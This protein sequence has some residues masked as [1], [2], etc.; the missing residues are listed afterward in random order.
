MMPIQHEYIRSLMI[1]VIHLEAFAG[2]QSTRLLQEWYY[3][4]IDT[5]TFRSRSE[6]DVDIIVDLFTAR[7]YLEYALSN[8]YV[9]LNDAMDLITRSEISLNRYAYAPITKWDRLR[10]YIINITR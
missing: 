2:Y 5:D 9:W 6:S 3:G 1:K 8:N 7:M 4:R 10:R